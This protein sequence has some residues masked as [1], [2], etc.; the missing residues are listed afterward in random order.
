MI[1]ALS[2]HSKKGTSKLQESWVNQYGPT[3]QLKGM[4]SVSWPVF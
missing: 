2:M 1:I 3:I 4:L